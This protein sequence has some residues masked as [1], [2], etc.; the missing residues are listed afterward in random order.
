MNSIKQQS[1]L[2]SSLQTKIK[3]IPKEFNFGNIKK[4]DGLN[5]Y[6]YIKNEGERNFNI[7]SIKSNCDCIT[8]FYGTAQFI[9]PN[10]SI[11]VEY[12][13]N[14]NNKGLFSNSIIAIGN[15]PNGNATYFF[16]GNIY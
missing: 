15:C 4:S 14:T 16:Q 8:T 6:F 2:D 1:F 12:I 10:D 5:G 9:K 7:V 13:F 3:L 11:K